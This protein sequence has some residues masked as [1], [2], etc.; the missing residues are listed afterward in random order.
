MSS[1]TEDKLVALLKNSK[2]IMNK[3]EENTFSRGNIDPSMLMTEGDLVDTPVQ[4]NTMVNRQPV[5]VPN[6]GNKFKNVANTKMPKQI[7]EAM[8]N[9]PI[10][11]PETPFHTF[12]LSENL[13]KQINSNGSYDQYDYEEKPLPNKLTQPPKKQVIKTQI[14]ESSSDIRKIIR[15]EISKILPEIVAEY[16]DKR[17]VTEQIQVK[18]GNTLFSGNLKPLPSKQNKK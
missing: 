5:N 15:E 4:N 11:I 8:L 12:D 10:E 14:N 13:V 17:V 2:A 6:S 16:F 1:L 7:V 9:D 18:V 3:V